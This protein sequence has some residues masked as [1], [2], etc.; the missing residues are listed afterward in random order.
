MQLQLDPI[1]RHFNLVKWYGNNWTN[2]VIIIHQSAWTGTNLNE[3]AP[4]FLVK[5]KIWA[6]HISVSFSCM[7][8]GWF[9]HFWLS[10]QVTL[11]LSSE[12]KFKAK[13]FC[14]FGVITAEQ[15]FLSMVTIPYPNFKSFF[16]I[17]QIYI[18]D[19]LLTQSLKISIFSINT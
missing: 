1:R 5:K 18:H 11:L 8:K 19:Q 10:M 12:G 17:I 15:H 4:H 14:C 7:F 13:D 3:N 2:F 9:W 16:Y 6:L